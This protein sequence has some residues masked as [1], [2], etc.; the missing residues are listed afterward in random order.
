MVF[1]PHA[2]GIAKWKSRHFLRTIS[3]MGALCYVF[4]VCLIKYGMKVK[5]IP[6]IGSNLISPQHNKHYGIFY[7]DRN[8]FES[9]V[10]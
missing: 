1:V 7:Q 2:F 8:I 6:L 5:N 4:D 10:K 9:I 3:S